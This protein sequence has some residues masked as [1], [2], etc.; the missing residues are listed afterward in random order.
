MKEPTIEL[1]PYLSDTEVKHLANQ[2]GLS[3][4]EIRDCLTKSNPKQCIEEKKRIKSTN[5]N[6]KNED[7]KEVLSKKPEEKNVEI[8][9]ELD[10][11]MMV[12]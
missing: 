6:K 9:E 12:P 1:T 5:L 4:E 11:G 3:Y 10:F 7:E 2:H 8:E